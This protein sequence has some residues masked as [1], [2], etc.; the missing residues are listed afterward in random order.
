MN[1]TKK[2]YFYLNID[3]DEQAAAIKLLDH[4]GQGKK[5][6]AIKSVLLSGFSLKQI[7]ERLPLLVASLIAKPTSLSTLAKVIGVLSPDYNISQITN[8]KAKEIV[9]WQKRVRDQLL[10]NNGWSAWISITES[11]YASLITKNDTDIQVRALIGAINGDL[12]NESAHK[13]AVLAE[14]TSI[15]SS[16]TNTV[17]SKANK[18][19]NT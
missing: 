13:K 4:L 12:I 5:S 19:F 11:E 6:A 15:A 8:E 14:K 7:D 16:H 3:K 10:P 1:K 2:Y 17:I 9:A 18:L